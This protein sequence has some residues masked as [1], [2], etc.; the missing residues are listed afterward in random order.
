[1]IS[2]RA[3]T[4]LV[5]ILQQMILAFLVVAC[6]VEPT[7][8]LG[9]SESRLGETE[10]LLEPDVEEVNLAR[11]NNVRTGELIEVLRPL[12]VAPE[13]DSNIVILWNRSGSIKQI[14]GEHFSIDV[15]RLNCPSDGSLQSATCVLDR[16]AQ[17]LGLVDANTGLVH[18]STMNL[19]GGFIAHRFRQYFET[20]PVRGSDIILLF[21]SSGF[22]RQI[23]SHFIQSLVVSQAENSTIGD[24]LGSV[25]LELLRQ[26]IA[27][28]LGVRSVQIKHREDQ[29]IADVNSVR[30]LG[31]PV[32]VLDVS[33]GTDNYAQFIISALDSRIISSTNAVP[34]H[35]TNKQYDYTRIAYPQHTDYQCPCYGDYTCATDTTTPDSCVLLPSF[36]HP[37]HDF[38]SEWYSFMSGEFDDHCHARDSLSSLPVHSGGEWYNA[39]YAN[40]SR[41]AALV[42]MMDSVIEFH[43]DDLSM[44]SWDNGGNVYLTILNNCCVDSCSSYFQGCHAP[45]TAPFGEDYVMIN[46]WH[47]IDSLDTG[48]LSH[49]YGMLSHEW[50]HRMTEELIGGVFNQGTCLNES[51]AYGYGSLLATK[52]VGLSNLH[53]EEV[54]GEDVTV[55]KSAWSDERE[56]LGRGCTEKMIPYNQ[57]S[58]IDWFDCDGKVL[59]GA[60]TQESQCGNYEICDSEYLQCSNNADPH[61]NRYIWNRFLRVLAEGTETFSADGN[62]E[63]VA[64]VFNGVSR[65]TA[66]SIHHF[67]VALSDVNTSLEE[68][69]YNL[70][71][72]GSAYGKLEE[73]KAALG[74]IGFMGVTE[75]SVPGQVT[76]KAWYQYYYSSWALSSQKSFSVWKKAGSTDIGVYYHN[77][78][79]WTIDTIT[80]NTNASPTVAEYK[81]KLYIFWRDA[82]NGAIKYAYYSPTGG[83]SRYVTLYG[84]GLT[85]SGAFDAVEFNDNLY[86]VFSRLANTEVALAKCNASVCLAGNWYNYGGGYY[87]RPLGYHAF[88]GLGVDES[89]NLNGTQ[90]T[91]GL[92]VVSANNVGGDDFYRVRIDMIGTDEEITHTEWMPSN[93]PSSRTGLEIGVRAVPSAF[94]AAGDYLY[95]AWKDINIPRA[96]LGILQELDLEDDSSTWIT[97]SVNTFAQTYRGVRFTRGIAVSEGIVKMTI[98]GVTN[99]IMSTE[100]YGRY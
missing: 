26:R 54:C 80:A 79:T 44:D 5:Q 56:G 47:G 82:G 42:S 97:R 89:Q 37:C 94:D 12:F 9:S 30:A 39:A 48:S 22:L 6:S 27:A 4:I 60:C 57:R 99:E 46:S 76:D 92:Y 91:P 40:Y 17:Y 28:T 67:A 77:G 38:Y 68:W 70:R 35:P 84:L 90:S 83:I 85:S 25:D 87:Y 58:R 74:I 36:E 65:T 2:Q 61:N 50:G 31:E 88:A 43:Y 69:T 52:K 49:N 81:Q 33:T 75:S 63:D 32:V 1:M 73:V 20:Y 15:S 78:T 45:A 11:A 51:V 29:I 3:G 8:N 16:T 41:F 95:I 66:A 14:W 71:A 53:W 64:V 96:Y 23:N 62:G 93:Y 10:N 34:S 24:T 19:N 13:G 100:L 86:I 7:A 72:A 59:G 55:T 18:V 98:G 21:D